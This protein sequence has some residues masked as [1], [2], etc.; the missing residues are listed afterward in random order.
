LGRRSSSGS[1]EFSTSVAA[2]PPYPRI[3]STVPYLPASGRTTLTDDLARA[4]AVLTPASVAVVGDDIQL[5]EALVAR[6][7]SVTGTDEAQASSAT[8]AVVHVRP[9]QLDEVLGKL[10]SDVRRVVLWHEGDVPDTAWLHAAAS[11]GCFRSATAIPQVRGATCALLDVAPVAVPD[12]VARYEALL[13]GGPSA[14]EQLSALRHQ[15]LTS[16]DHAIG[17]EA[18]IA[19]LRAHQQ[20]LEDQ[21]DDLLATT[22]WRVGTRIVGPVGRLKQM[23]RR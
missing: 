1:V 6:G 8:L 5:A 21:I 3:N 15:L 9:A 11:A 17:A 4:I 13:S 19:Q 16:R 10:A 20:E 7:L 23:L 14:Q 22:T 12:L 2:H 18:E